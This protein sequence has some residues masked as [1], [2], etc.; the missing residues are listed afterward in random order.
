MSYQGELSSSWLPCSSHSDA[1]TKKCR[2]YDVS[3]SPVSLL[4]DAEFSF[5]LDLCLYLN[6]H[7]VNAVF[8]SCVDV[9]LELT[10]NESTYAAQ[11]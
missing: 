2:L 4:Q 3:K 7:Y 11:T 8:S 1:D 6:C 5:S 10:G 9:P